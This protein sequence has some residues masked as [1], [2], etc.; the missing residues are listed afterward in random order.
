MTLQSLHGT[1]CVS[2]L[3]MRVH[4][5]II[6]VMINTTVSASS[7]A[8]SKHARSHALG[9]VDHHYDYLDTQ[10]HMHTHKHTHTKREN[11][12]QIKS[13]CDSIWQLWQCQSGGL[14]GG[15][16]TELW[17]LL[18]RVDVE[19][20][21]LAPVCLPPLV[22]PAMGSGLWALAVFH[23]GCIQGHFSELQV[24]KATVCT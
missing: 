10:T 7:A 11:T 18:G 22:L 6:I 15:L 4:A 2:S 3:Y 1:L 12:E 20:L 13:D 14:R 21:L 23:A 19:P 5:Q 9:T 8:G 17:C 16:E 24:A